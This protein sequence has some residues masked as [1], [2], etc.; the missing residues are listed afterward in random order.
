[1]YAKALTPNRLIDPGHANTSCNLQKILYG[2]QCGV[3]WF[4]DLIAGT[5]FE[6]VQKAESADENEIEALFVSDSR[7]LS[8][9]RKTENI[10][11]AF[12]GDDGKICLHPDYQAD[13]DSLSFVAA[14]CR[15]A[16][17]FHTAADN[18]KLWRYTWVKLGTR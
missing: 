18:P 3:K 17:F 7:M 5:L 9:R 12:I 6:G 13:L 1:M 2:K 14:G 8:L 4:G 16:T 10:P 11:V 15:N